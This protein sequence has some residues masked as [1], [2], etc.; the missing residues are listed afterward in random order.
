MKQVLFAV[1][2]LGVVAV[3]VAMV[4]DIRRYIK[5]NSM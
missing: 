5:I 3:V 2:G 1:L 4:P